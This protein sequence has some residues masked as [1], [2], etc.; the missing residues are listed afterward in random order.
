MYIICFGKW[1]CKGGNIF[2]YR[3]VFTNKGTALPLVKVTFR[4][5]GS[6]PTLYC[7]KEGESMEELLKDIR[8]ILSC[9][10]IQLCGIA[11]SLLVILFKKK[12]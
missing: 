11:I 8:W 9:H 2:F 4:H 1:N 5:V 6:P 3:R 12:N 10:S 7:L